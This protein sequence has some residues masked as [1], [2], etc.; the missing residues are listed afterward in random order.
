MRTKVEG[1]FLINWIYA[2]IIIL[3]IFSNVFSDKLEIFLNLKPNITYTNE[4]QVHII[5]VGQ[6]DAIAI[7]FSN[8]KTM[9]VDS[10]TEN[11]RDK[12]VNYLNKVVLDNTKSI[13]YVVL[14]HPDIDH[15]SNMK[16]IIEN[17]EV[18]NFFR[19]Q[20]YEFYENKEPYCT[21]EVYRDML[22]SLEYSNAN[23][24]FHNDMELIDGDI[25]IK[26]LTVFDSDILISKLDSNQ[27]SPVIIV[28]DNDKK[29][30]LTGDI[31]T[32]IE[33]KIIEKY[34]QDLLD[35][36][37]FKLAHHGSKYSNSE[38]FLN[39]ITPDYVCV[40]TGENSYGH[41]ANDT[42]ER[43]LKYDMVHNT[44]IFNNFLNTKQVGNIIYTLFEDGIKIDTIKNIDNY[45][46]VDY[47]IYSIILISFILWLLFI[48]YYIALRKDIRFYIQNKKH[49]KLKEKELAKS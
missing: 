45:N 23:I 28:S 6:G 24:Y 3:V 48:P 15:S 1:R 21:N 8:G 40:S 42:L 12:L 22:V 20:L 18:K 19:P 41:P 31:D 2:I 17:Y 34:S 30:M 16:Y 25:S 38:E 46:F 43:L 10:G 7:R 13:D 4:T 47:Y 39:T 14:T 11:Y 44:N 35:V 29:I 5:D 27:F 36:D 49:K 9:L 37:I 26:F 32:V 33:E